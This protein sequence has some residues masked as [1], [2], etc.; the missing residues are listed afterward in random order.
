MQIR[1]LTVTVA[2]LENSSHSRRS[3]QFCAHVDGE[4]GTASSSPMP[5]PAVFHVFEPGACVHVN[6]SPQN[7]SRRAEQMQSTARV[8]IQSRDLEGH[9][10]LAD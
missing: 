3:E 2:W 10:L 1:V 4:R 8:F 6:E 7:R 9:V 5:T